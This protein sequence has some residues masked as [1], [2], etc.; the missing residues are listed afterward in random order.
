MHILTFDLECWFHAHNLNVP[1]YLWSSRND[2][3]DAVLPPLL[4]QLDK[5][6]VRATFF[7]LGWVA[8]RR[9]DW[10]RR[11]HSAGHEIA[12]H[13]YEH[14][15]ITTQSPREFRRDVLDSLALLQH[16]TGDP[17]LG[18][19]APSYSVVPQTAWALEILA[20]CGLTYDSSIVPIRAPHR[21]YGW[22]GAPTAPWQVLP[23]F[24]ELPLPTVGWGIARIPAAAGAYLRLLPWAVTRA[25]LRGAQSSD[26]PAI[27]N[28][29]PWE[30]D[31]DQ[32]RW[33]TSFVRRHLH[34]TGIAGMPSRLNK[35]L[36]HCRFCSAADWLMENIG[37][38]QSRTAETLIERSLPQGAIAPPPTRPTPSEP[39]AV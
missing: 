23:G 16:L 22:P 11:I 24:W 26:R 15:R 12:S 31:A 20:E 7:V 35:L 4:D 14:R 5:N 30:L 3:L 33:P 18:Y 2:R 39:S 6:K 25:A 34:Y 36:Q 38:V 10:V 21:R 27:V 28:I 37:P 29:H 17:V 1:K 8:R 32:P 13:G 9:P 19:R